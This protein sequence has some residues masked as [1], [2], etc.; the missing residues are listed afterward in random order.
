MLIK[1][2]NIED[3]TEKLEKDYGS[4]RPIFLI[5]LGHTLPWNNL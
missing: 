2:G 3:E 1:E 5:I 4:G